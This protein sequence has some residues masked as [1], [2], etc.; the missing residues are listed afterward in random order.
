MIPFIQCSYNDQVSDEVHWLP[1]V[2]MDGEGVARRGHTK[3]VFVLME[4][5][6]II[7]VTAVRIH[8]CD[9]IS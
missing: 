6:C 2:R 5:S 4:Q 3:E 9:K 1:Q 7:E 8:T